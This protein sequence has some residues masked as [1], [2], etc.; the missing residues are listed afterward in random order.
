MLSITSLHCCISKGRKVEKAP[1]FKISALYIYPFIQGYISE[2][3]ILF[4]SL[5]L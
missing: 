3:K 5:K 1:I 4:I 2:E